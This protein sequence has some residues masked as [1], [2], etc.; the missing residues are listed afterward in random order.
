MIWSCLE[1]LNKSAAKCN[2][3]NLL[4]AT[5]CENWNVAFHSPMQRCNLKII[6]KLIDAE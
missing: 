3:Q 6:N 4:P 2:I 5:D 1:V